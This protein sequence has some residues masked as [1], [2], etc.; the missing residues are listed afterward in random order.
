MEWEEM[1]KNPAGL[2]MKYHYEYTYIFHKYGHQ[3]NDKFDA[4]TRAQSY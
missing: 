2:D 1:R 3:S 4:M